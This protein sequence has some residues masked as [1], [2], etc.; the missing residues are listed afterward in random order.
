MSEPRFQPSGLAAL[1]VNAGAFSSDPMAYVDVGASGGIPEAW[2]SFA[3]DLRVDG[4]EPLLR[5][6]ER[7]NAESRSA[8]ERYHARLVGCRD[9]QFQ[10][11]IQADPISHHNNFSRERTSAI[12]YERLMGIT[13]P[14]ARFNR[15]D[16]DMS[17]AD[18][19]VTLD[20]FFVD[21]EGG[22]ANV[23]FLKIDTDGYDLEIL[24]GAER[25]LRES[26]VLGVHVECQFHGRT[27]PDSQTFANIDLFLRERGFTLHD[28]STERYSRAALPMPFKWEDC[29][30]NTVVGQIQ[31]G[32]ALY[33]R[34]LAD[35]DYEL[36]NGSGFSA[37]K[38]LKLAALFEIFQ[39]PDCAAELILA[40]RKDFAGLGFD[41]VGNW[42]DALVPEIDGRQASYAEHTARFERDPASF[43]PDQAAVRAR[44]AAR[45][46][47]MRRK[48]QELV[49][50]VA[51]LREKIAKKNET[52]AAAAARN[53]SLS[54]EIERLR[55]ELADAK[56][57]LPFF[58]KR[59]SS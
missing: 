23:D 34:D 7:L 32:D 47:E 35:P 46:E 45:D 5:E 39:L 13:H 41:D 16:A 28:L 29:P 11:R 27:H 10:D 37:A 18:E 55:A 58:G 52:L 6:A 54:R 57:R 33:F 19:L 8:T 4:F 59:K 53:E 48:R 36:K 40:R 51:E 15:G 44:A 20:E 30:A 42:L 50:K 22:A 31:W 3:P 1:L 14:Q 12:R 38:A 26:G 43:L 56:P 49:A 2:R 9:R 17:V 24:F 21:R 25:M